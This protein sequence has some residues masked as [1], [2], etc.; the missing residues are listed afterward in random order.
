MLI[1]KVKALTWRVPSVFCCVCKSLYLNNWYQSRCLMRDLFIFQT[2][3][4][5]RHGM[6][7]SQQYI[8]VNKP[9]KLDVTHYGYWKIQMAQLI[10]GIDM[11]DWIDVED[12]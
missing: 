9:L 2:G 8:A 7:N 4:I 12:G 11:E 10:Q 1:K 3:E 5:L 6:E